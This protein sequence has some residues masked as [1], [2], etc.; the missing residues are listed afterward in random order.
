MPILKLNACKI[1][2]K[3]K[4]LYLGIKPINKDIAKE[5]L[6]LFNKILTANDVKFGLLYG[7]L[8]GAVRDHDFI[9]HDED[10]DLFIL[11]ENRTYFLDVL[12][13]L[14]RSG[15]KVIRYDRRDLISIERKGEYIDIYIFRELEKGIRFCS[16]LCVLESFLVETC[17]FDFL[18]DKFLIPKE[19]IKY[20]EFEYGMD[21]N[22]PIPYTDFKISK[23][24]L[25]LFTFKEAIKTI[26]PEW[27][28]LKI[29]SY[30]DKS[31]IRAFKKRYLEK[32]KN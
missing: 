25:C 18:G 32:T 1:V 31:K 13:I 11:D 21:W 16:G 15:F 17:W 24:Q 19:Y 4:P 10:I 2:Y 3:S 22:I 23:L 20:L 7:T 12:L 27:I 9:S 8:L 29:L 5:N 14:Y 6:L 30:R 28:Y 26:I